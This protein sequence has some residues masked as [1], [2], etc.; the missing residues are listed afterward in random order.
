MVR[1]FQPVSAKPDFPVFLYCGTMDKTLY[2]RP[3]HQKE[4]QRIYRN[5]KAKDK[6]DLIK[7]IERL[8]EVPSVRVVVFFATQDNSNR[9][10]SKAS[11]DAKY[12]LQ[13]FYKDRT[14]DQRIPSPWPGEVQNE[15]VSGSFRRD[16][17]DH[18]IWVSKRICEAEDIHFA[19]V[20]SHELQHLKQSLNNPYLLIVAKL[21]EYVKYEIPAID[22]PTEFECDGKA[23]Q[24]TIRIFGEEKCISYLN[25]MKTGSRDNVVRYNKLLQLSI[26]PDFD[27]EQEIQQAICTNQKALKE[28]QKQRQNNGRTNWN[29]DIDKLCS[30]RDPHKAIVSAVTKRA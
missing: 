18:F 14:L 20:Y 6:E 15:L 8:I 1:A 19:W 25:K 22:I 5:E 10:F 23:K 26:T 29:I 27:V 3:W 16:C 30:C 2:V 28:I 12:D 9:P 21:L 4:M 13:G 11:F 24:I 17:C 7:E